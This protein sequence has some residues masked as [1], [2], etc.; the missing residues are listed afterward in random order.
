MN[1][2]W[3][4]VKCLLARINYVRRSSCRRSISQH[5]RCCQDNWRNAEGHVRI[6]RT[7]A[8]SFR[9]RSVRWI[10]AGFRL[11]AKTRGAT[12]YY[13][14]HYIVVLCLTE[15]CLNRYSCCLR[16]IQSQR[17]QSRRA[18]GSLQQLPLTCLST[19]PAQGKLKW[20]RDTCPCLG[21]ISAS[22]NLILQKVYD[23][24]MSSFLAGGG[25]GYALLKGKIIEHTLT[26]DEH[27][28]SLTSIP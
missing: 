22:C 5:G 27:T 25:D 20:Q 7:R 26:G 11:L 4:D 6:F 1:A 8:R 10:P 18:L 28:K 24:A 15:S 19:R 2:T 12:C 9:P 13:K 17:R 16:H 3:N 14:S 23:V 21:F